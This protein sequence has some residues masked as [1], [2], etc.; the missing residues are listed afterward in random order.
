MGVEIAINQCMNCVHMY[1]FLDV[2]DMNVNN[3]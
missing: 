2:I 1:L 3:N